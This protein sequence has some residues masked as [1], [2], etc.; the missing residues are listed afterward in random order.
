MSTKPAQMR[1]RLRRALARAKRTG[2]DSDLRWEIENYTRHTGLK[3][4]V[5]WD[6]EELAHG[7]PRN[8]SG[9]FAGAIPTWITPDV[10]RE[11]KK[12]LMST[13][14]GRLGANV[15]LAIRT[16]VNL[17]ENEEVDDK[18]RPIV[19]PRTKLAASQFIIEHII[20]KPDKLITL[21]A[22]DTA[23]QMLASAIVLDTGVEDS[24]LVIEGEIAEDPDLNG[25]DDE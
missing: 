9:G 22:T 7:R 17:L 1:N 12:R 18:G 16:V 23:R 2:D 20:G 8:A 10:T 6:M 14:Y 11:A 25:D 15:D 13:A 4:V 19:D 5:D 21:D 24:H 3:P